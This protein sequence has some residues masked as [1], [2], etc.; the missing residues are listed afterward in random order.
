MS[1]LSS[2]LPYIIKSNAAIIL[3]LV[4]NADIVNIKIPINE[5]EDDSMITY[6]SSIKI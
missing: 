3:D 1:S 5:I 2:S 4:E 6:K